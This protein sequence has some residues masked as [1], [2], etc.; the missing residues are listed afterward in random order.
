MLQSTNKKKI[1]FYLASFLF[2]TTIF[3]NNLIKE[4][5][6]TVKISEIKIENTKKEIDHIIVSNTN[7]LLDKN[8]F[9]INKKL[10]LEKLKK[11][12][13]IESI[14]IKK[15]YPSTIN[16]KTKITSLIAITYIDQKKYFVGRNGNFISEK[17]ISNE[18]QLPIIFGKFNVDD[19]IL[20]QKK[21]LNQKVD[22]NE[23]IRYYFHKNKRWDLYLKNNIL[24]QL[25]HKK[26][27]SAINLYK[28]FKINNK[29]NPNA[30]IDLRISNRLIFKNG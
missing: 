15:E 2:I 20:L 23:V 24:I 12:N 8:I 16:I 14:S 26:I 11:L 30:I 25:P 7:F 19:Y 28:Q 27:D 3:N 5:G 9:S 1:Y 4:L 18:K 22:L 6:S 13:F 29:I 21:L 10:I 17:K